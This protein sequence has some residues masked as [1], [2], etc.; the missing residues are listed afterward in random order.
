MADDPFGDM[1]NADAVGEDAV[2]V[3]VV[4]QDLMSMTHWFPSQGKKAAV[5]VTFVLCNLGMILQTPSTKMTNTKCILEVRPQV[6]PA[7][8]KPL[9]SVA[10]LE[11]CSA[12]RKTPLA[13]RG[14]LPA[15][16]VQRDEVW[17]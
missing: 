1:A 12:F 4:G 7:P 2:G 8:S 10:M 14:S 16:T 9:Q 11:S 15:T 17:W 5:K 6:L 13:G 3:D